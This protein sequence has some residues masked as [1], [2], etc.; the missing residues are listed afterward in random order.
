ML[1]KYLNSIK[2]VKFAPQVIID[3]SY[4]KWRDIRDFK[5][6]VIRQTTNARQRINLRYQAIKS[7]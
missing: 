2:I 1:R 5:L 7:E 6:C 3:I 4:V